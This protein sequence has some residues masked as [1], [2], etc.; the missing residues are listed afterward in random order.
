MTDVLIRPARAE[1]AADIALVHVESWQAA[2]RGLLPQDYLD[3]L[4]P[5][6]RSEVWHQRLSQPGDRSHVLVA[7]TDAGVSGFVSIGPSRDNDADA[8]R[9]GE[10]FAIYVHPDAWGTGAGRALMAATV[11]QLATSEFRD[12]T[13]WVLDTNSRARRF[14]AKAGWTADD[15]TQRDESRGFPIIEIRYRLELRGE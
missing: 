12:A 2:Y 14:Y 6:Q 4:D 15:A 1:D 3:A 9:T 8:Q 10:V 11:E 5:A 13:L 7:E